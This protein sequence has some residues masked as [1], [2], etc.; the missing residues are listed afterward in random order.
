MSNPIIL[1]DSILIPPATVIVQ[2]GDSPA[3]EI[4][5]ALNRV[6]LLTLRITEAVEQEYLELELMG[7]SDGTTWR[8]L[9]AVPQRFYVGEYPTLM[10]L[11]A[12]CD[13]RLLRVHW[14]VARWG[15]GQLTPHFICGLTLRE[16]P[17]DVVAEAR[18]RRS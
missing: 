7:S 18:A 1:V 16:V 2:K 12:D 9:A 15:R 6:F 14:E 10:D 5:E 11:N 4:S 3:V 13:T 8:P 17:L